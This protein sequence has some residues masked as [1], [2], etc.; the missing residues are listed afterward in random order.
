MKTLHEA[1]QAALEALENVNEICTETCEPQTIW[2]QDEINDLRAALEAHVPEADCGNMAA[3]V[4]PLTDA[5]V[6][7]MWYSS[8]FRGSGGQVD[9]FEEGVRAA[10]KHH[11]IGGKP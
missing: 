5:A 1:G 7:K 9:W 2:V 3:Q 8:E 4:E 10:E 6:Q 11:G